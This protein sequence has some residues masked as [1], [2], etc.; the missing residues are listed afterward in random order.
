MQVEG[1]GKSRVVFFKIN[2]VVSR[3]PR[4]SERLQ[5]DSFCLTLTMLIG[6]NCI[7]FIIRCYCILSA[8]VE[9]DYILAY[10]EVQRLATIVDSCFTR[11]SKKTFH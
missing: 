11:A 1:G 8:I 5:I 7:L 2:D 3:E 6:Q 10:E 9:Q 4:A